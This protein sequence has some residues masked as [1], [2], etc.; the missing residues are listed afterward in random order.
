MFSVP[1]GMFTKREFYCAPGAFLARR[2]LVRRS[3][4][5]FPTSATFDALP[6]L[7]IDISHPIVR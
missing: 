6:S 3:V 7:E 5:F 4:C 2:R 1:V